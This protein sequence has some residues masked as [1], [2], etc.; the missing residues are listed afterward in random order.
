MLY[1]QVKR[2]IS[3]QT[4]NYIVCFFQDVLCFPFCVAQIFAYEVVRPEVDKTAL[5]VI[6]PL[7]LKGDAKTGAGIQNT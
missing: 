3:L 6:R 7:D 5:P 4:V 1:D 2:E